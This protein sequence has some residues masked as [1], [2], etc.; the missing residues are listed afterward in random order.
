M[1]NSTKLDDGEKRVA[2]KKKTPARAPHR[3]KAAPEE[4]V[5]DDV[6]EVY[7]LVPLMMKKTKVS[8]YV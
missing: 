2:K 1:K 5:G 8:C 4:K 6:S 7:G 3:N